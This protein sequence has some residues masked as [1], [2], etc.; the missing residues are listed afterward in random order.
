M[1]LPDG[2][3]VP[4][5]TKLEINTCSIHADK[6]LY[7]NPEEFDGLRFYKMRQGPGQ[8]NKYKYSS[9]GRED[10]SWG[11]GRHAC[12]GRYLS[13]VN[14]KLILAELLMNYDI[15]LCEGAKRPPN[16][17]FEVLVSFSYCVLGL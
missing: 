5:G 15:K 10:L 6:D 2:T 9:V 16:I 7:E 11:F 1:T 4:K 12:P 8:E 14:I 17:E 3:F 13:E